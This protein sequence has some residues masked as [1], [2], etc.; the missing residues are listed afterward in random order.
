MIQQIVC[1]WECNV[2][3][4]QW[5]KLMRGRVCICMHSNIC[6]CMRVHMYVYTYVSVESVDVRLYANVYVST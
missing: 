2:V 6:V 5:L 4:T 1:L 3:E